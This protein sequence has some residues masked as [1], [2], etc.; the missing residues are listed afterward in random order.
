MAAGFEV[1]NHSV[2]AGTERPDAMF[3]IQV[4]SERGWV[5]VDLDAAQTALTAAYAS[6][7]D[8]LTKRVEAARSSKLN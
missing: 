4:L 8:E 1:R 7:F 6:A 5:A 2:A 3:T